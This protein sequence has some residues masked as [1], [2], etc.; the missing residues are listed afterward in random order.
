M[1]KIVFC[2]MAAAS[3]MAMAWLIPPATQAQRPP[4]TEVVNCCAK[5]GKCEKM[6]H[7]ACMNAGGKVVENCDKCEKGK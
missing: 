2:L 4:D 6:T 3:V 7:K 1:R 5:T